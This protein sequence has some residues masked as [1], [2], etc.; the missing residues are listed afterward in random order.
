MN[1]FLAGAARF[2]VVLALS[3]CSG[4]HIGSGSDASGGSENGGGSGQSAGSAGLSA[5]AGG[6]TSNRDCAVGV[7]NAGACKEVSCV[8]GAQ[9]CGDGGVHSCNPD[10]T[11]GPVLQHC[12]PT[13]FCL[14]NGSTAGCNATACVPGDHLCNGAL[15]TTCQADGSGP[16]PGGDDCSA[17]KQLCFAGQCLDQLCTPGQKLCDAGV[18]YLCGNSGTARQAVTTCD[19]FQVCD[20]AQGACVQKLCD[21]GKLYCDSTRVVGCNTTGDAYVQTG[22]DCA[23]SNS[24][25]VDGACQPITCSPSYEFCKDNSVFQC[26]PQGT[27]S[28]LYYTCEPPQLCVQAGAGASCESPMCTPGQVTCMGSS[29]NTCSSDGT[30]WLP[31]NDCSATGQACVNGQ[32]GSPVC[33]AN[34]SFCKNNSVQTCDS[35]GGSFSQSQ[36]CGA[37]L[38]CIAASTTAFCAPLSCTAGAIACVG[39]KLGVCAADGLGVTSPLDCNAAQ[40]VCT[41]QG[42]VASLVDT[43]NTETDVEESSESTFVGDVVLVD[44]SRKLSEIAANLTVPAGRSLTWAVYVETDANFAGEFDLD[45]QKT[46]TASGAGTESSGAL[47]V[48]LAVGK[49]YLLG[50]VSSGGGFA[51]YAG[52]P[53]AAP[54]LSFGHIT[55]G[56]AYDFE[57]AINVSPGLSE[58]YA[59][60]FTTTAP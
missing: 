50:V 31:G 53:T 29:V 16:N 7:C 24:A 8:P 20:Q 12:S 19:S 17:K 36:F 4:S 55:S 56:G 47:G 41:P 27:S 18:L 23:T 49:S 3:A 11:P 38:R 58:V 51:L 46:T 25:C 52:F 9:F 54:A 48:E 30:Q 10:G 59:L 6:C 32:C 5:G 15:A 34:S 1:R 22:T 37:Q 40:K 44:T 26:S 39:D 14:E 13:Q 35:A 33:T 43:V 60:R 21:T 42:C 28:M 57:S 2:S 45:F